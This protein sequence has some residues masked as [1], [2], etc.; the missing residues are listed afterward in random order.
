MTTNVI[1]IW[2]FSLIIQRI[3]TAN[4]SIYSNLYSSNLKTMKLVSSRMARVRTIF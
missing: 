4:A 1:I 3:L 2:I